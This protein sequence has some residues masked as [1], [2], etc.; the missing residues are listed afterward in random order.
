MQKEKR[1]GEGAE[2]RRSSQGDLCL[3]LGLDL[4]PKQKGCNMKDGSHV[5][6]GLPEAPSW[7]LSTCSL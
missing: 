4:G 5:L 1:E 2:A 7:D 6:R 3:L